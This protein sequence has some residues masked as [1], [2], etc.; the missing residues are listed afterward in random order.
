MQGV[1]LVANTRR[2]LVVGGSVGGMAS[3]IS[4]QRAGFQVD[5]AEIDPAWMIYGAGLTITAPT[6]RALQVLGVLDEVTQQ[7]ATWELISV[8]TRDGER[9][10]ELRTPRISPELPAHGGIMRPV[11]HRILSSATRK[12]GVDVRLGTTLETMTQVPRG[13]EVKLTDGHRACYEIVV[14]ADGIYSK[15][16]ERIFPDAPKPTFTGQVIYRVVA[17]RPQ[18]FDRGEF[19]RSED[20]QLGFNPVSATHLYM[21]LLERQPANPWMPLEEQPRRLYQSLEGWGGIVPRVRAVVMTSSAPTVNYRP[22]EAML[23]P[24]PWFQGRVVLIGDAAHAATPHL[25]SGVGMAIED[26]LVLADELK[27][28]EI[29]VALPRFMDRRFDR[30]RMAVENSVRIG[31]IEMK[32]GSPDEQGRLLAESMQALRQPM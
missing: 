19:Y 13:V 11:L 1:T 4:L 18:G 22:L 24:R 14:G 28:G 5:L 32:H 20:A 23:L 26:A 27:N 29:D 17:E 25:A 2:A 8:F 7:G 9:I 15:L 31:E 6:L 21:Y 30:S 12:A 10:Q 16:R 3:A